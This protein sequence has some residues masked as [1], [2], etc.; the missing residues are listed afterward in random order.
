MRK[1]SIT[2][3][4][5]IAILFLGNRVEACDYCMLSQGISPLET[6]K[7]KGI[8][9]TERYTVLKSVYQRDDKLDIHGAKEKYWTTEFTGFYGITEKLTLLA[10]VPVKKN[11]MEGH[12]HVHSDGSTGVH[13]DN[14]GDEFGLGD[15]AVLGRYTFLRKHSLDTTT[16]IAG[17]AGVKFPNGKTDGRREDNSSRYLDS[18]MQPGTGSTDFLLGLSMSHSVRRLTIS[19]NLL[20]AITTEGEAG[21]EKHQFGNSLNYDLTARYRVYPDV[22][23]PSGQ[24]LFFAFGING[25]V[26][27]KEEE[28]G[29]ELANSGGHTVYLSPGVQVVMSPHW[30][31]ELSYSHPVYH[32]LN[33][34]QLGEDYKISGGVT[35]LF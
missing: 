29:V 18:H 20:G 16:N 3:L 35:Y 25:E 2:L 5:F 7:G 24:Q 32:K 31:F 13:T 6:I 14:K 27:G 22:I 19:T 21:N 23:S 17:L 4:F 12:F 34:I 15:V 8:R 28:E 26:R 30:V 33:G 11:I 9:I 1:L 10:V